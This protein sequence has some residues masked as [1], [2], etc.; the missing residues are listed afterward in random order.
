MKKE[1][2]R[3]RGET[4]K[5]PERVPRPARSP[6]PP[7]RTPAVSAMI[8]LELPEP[9]LVELPYGEFARL[10]IDES[11]QRLKITSW[12]ESL[13]SIIKADGDTPPLV[14]AE[15][16]GDRH[17]YIVD[18]QQRYWA[19]VQT[20]TG[21]RGLLYR[22]D[23]VEDERKYYHILNYHRPISGDNVV[24]SW[25]GETGQIIRKWASLAGSPYQGNVAFDHSGH[26]NRYS[27][28]ILARAVCA[29]VCPSPSLPLTGLRRLLA[30]TDAD[31]KIVAGSRERVDALMRLVALV[32]PP[33]SRLHMRVAV[34]FGRVAQRKWTPAVTGRFPSPA[35]QTR[36]RG[37][38]WATLVPDT[39]PKYDIVIEKAIEARWR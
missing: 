18:G 30:Q 3:T 11:Y 4:K 36:L 12:V 19:H 1:P 34:I 2:E 24:K 32:F 5:E 8:P 26:Q 39:N 31:L 6:T 38:N 22:F 14:L 7:K 29:V 28:A 16:P 27:A 17:W 13:V 9:K 37:V 10:L 35:S 20:T 25:P 33:R 21:T 15:R 23:S